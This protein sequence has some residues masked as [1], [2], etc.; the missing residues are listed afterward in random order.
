MSGVFTDEQRSKLLACI[1]K[2]FLRSGFDSFERFR[3]YKENK[4]CFI[5]YKPVYPEIQVISKSDD[6]TYIDNLKIMTAQNL[7]DS[8]TGEIVKLTDKLSKQL[9]ITEP[10]IN[11]WASEKW[12]GI[13]A[14][15]DGEKIISRGS[16]VGKP[17]VYTYVP[18]WFKMTLPPGVA[19]DGEIW[20]GRGMFQKTSRLSTLKP[21][22]SYTEKQIN[23]IWV[24]TEDPPVI[25]KVFDIPNE[26]A[27]FEQRMRLLQTIVRDRKDCWTKLNYPGK[28]IFP[29]QFTEQVKIKSMEQLVNLYTKLTSEGAEGIML[30]ASGSP[31]EIKRSKYMLKYKIKEDAECIVRGYTPGEGRLKGLLGSINCEILEDGK[32]SGVFTQIGTGLTDS[33]RENYIIPNHPE[34]IP[35]GSIVSF[36]YM[37][38]TKDNIPRHPVYRGIRDDIKKPKNDVTVKQ[39]K[40]ILTKLM[41][42]ISASKEQNW[43]F[44][45][46]YYKQAIDILNDTMQ[47]NT[48]ED[49]I[50]VFREN[51]MQLKDEENFKAKNGSWKSTILQKIDIIL[52]TGE[53]DNIS[54]DLE[55]LAIENLTKIPGI[56]PAKASELYKTEEITTITDLIEI[57]SVNKKVINDKQAIGLK[58][59]DDLQKRIPRSEMNSWKD[60]LEETFNETLTELNE[61]GKLVITGSY[62]REKP[63][64]GDI[65]ALITTDEYNKDL[66]NTFYNN[67]VKKN[68]ISPENVISKGPIKIMA[69]AAIDEIHRHL[70]IFYYTSDVYPF[71]LLFTTGSKELNV[72][73]RNHAIRKG[74]SL[75]ERNLTRNSPSGP[76]VS[77]DEYIRVISKPKPETEDDIFKFLDFRYLAPKDR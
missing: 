66:M 32:P 60:I 26:A 52:K 65:D 27:P 1:N 30:R 11:W 12:D 48:V 55:T 23:D 17:K 4:S 33:Q 29:L 54:M 50:K 3:L 70:D 75:N 53:V 41:N 13:R 51:G 36:S 37:E 28:R 72:N 21:G 34:A 63:D 38:M 61:T 19:L 39:V 44:K 67:L 10:P 57:Y 77:E 18:E 6:K 58:H 68:I 40:Y 16:G 76:T 49:Y 43:Q 47:L 8:K 15:W 64:S 22:K 42:K 35:I 14:L 59:Y 24:G 5:D 20:I 71:A 9:N 69:V 7:Y 73:M 62:R 46:R 56:G 2:I 45:A 25:F 31:Y 74:Y